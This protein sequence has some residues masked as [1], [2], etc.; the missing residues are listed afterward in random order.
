LI[1]SKADNGLL[2]PRLQND[3]DDDDFY[4]VQFKLTY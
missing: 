1:S 4:L 2:Q 3:D